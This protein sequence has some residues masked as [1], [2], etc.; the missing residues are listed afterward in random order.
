MCTQADYIAR[1]MA[2]NKLS[3][4]TAKPSRSNV[5]IDTA[6]HSQGI[7]RV[8][9]TKYLGAILDSSFMRR[10]RIDQV[11]KRVPLSCHALLLAR[12]CFILPILRQLHFALVQSHFIYSIASW[13]N[14]YPSYLEQLFR[15]QKTTRRFITFSYDRTCSVELFNNL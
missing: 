1:W 12:H 9:E 5:S 7:Q 13:A 11:M 10:K 4:N 6:I 14:I 2:R 15:L 8:D 3:F